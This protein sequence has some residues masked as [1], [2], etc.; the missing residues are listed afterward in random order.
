MLST[1]SQS[2]LLKSWFLLSTITAVLV[3]QATAAGIIVDFASTG[4]PPRLTQEWESYLIYYA[5]SNIDS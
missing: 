5:V 1:C 3:P 2:V 4:S